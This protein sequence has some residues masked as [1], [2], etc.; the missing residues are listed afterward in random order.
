MSS[1]K[2]ISTST[3][4]GSST[5]S[6]TFSNIPQIASHLMLTVYAKTNRSG[7]SND[8]FYFNGDNA[9]DGK[10]P[11]LGM[12]LRVYGDGAFTND[13]QNLNG[14]AGYSMM[15]P[16]ALPTVGHTGND[17]TF[18]SMQMWMPNYT[19]TTKYKTV[20]WR[21]GFADDSPNTGYY[22]ATSGIFSAEYQNT[23]TGLTSIT[24]S[25]EEASVYYTAGS[26]FSLYM[27]E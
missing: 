22:S 5:S 21:Y 24:F 16:N 1:L 9:T 10:Y 13:V 2:L 3:V 17:P 20:M 23:T 27:M 7:G 11:M 6:V 18:C 26:K 19:N 25:T 12:Y 4:S 15:Y 8:R 14:S